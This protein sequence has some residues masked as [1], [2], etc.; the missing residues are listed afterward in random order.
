MIN[1]IKQWDFK[2]FKINDKSIINFSLFLSIFA[3]VLSIP[4]GTPCLSANECQV[5]S[6]ATF[7]NDVNIKS[8]TNY[9]LTL[10]HNY[11][12][13][14][15]QQLA[16]MEQSDGMVLVCKYITQDGQM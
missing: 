3:L 15:H 5:G 7:T 12:F 14:V 1:R 2:N 8:G 4:S 10:G 13:W 9:N 6:D 11:W 16:P